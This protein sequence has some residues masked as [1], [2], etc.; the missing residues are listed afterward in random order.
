MQNTNT[1]WPA[2]PLDQIEFVLANRVDLE[3]RTGFTSAAEQH[4][5]QLETLQDLRKTL[6]QYLE[7]SSIDGRSERQALRAKLKSFV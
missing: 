5:V 2:S 4:K 3:T 6:F 7:L 1:Q